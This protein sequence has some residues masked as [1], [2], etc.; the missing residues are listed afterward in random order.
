MVEF[1]EQDEGDFPTDGDMDPKAMAQWI[2]D[3]VVTHLERSIEQHSAPVVY[4]WGNWDS[5]ESHV[6]FYSVMLSRTYFLAGIIPGRP[7]GRTRS[8]H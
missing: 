1:L 5:G 6:W 4:S 7:L 8:H 2:Q 3:N